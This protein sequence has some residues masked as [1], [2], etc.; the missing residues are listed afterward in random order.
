MD[1]FLSLL[2]GEFTLPKFGDSKLLI[3]EVCPRLGRQEWQ[4]PPRVGRAAGAY[5]RLPDPL[6]PAVVRH[7]CKAPA[8]QFPVQV[9]EKSRGGHGGLLDVRPLVD[10]TKLTTIG[11]DSVSV[12]KAKTYM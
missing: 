7:Q 1:A 3:T 6:R 5:L 12:Y 9:A 11:D 4:H 8:A 10:A 2:I